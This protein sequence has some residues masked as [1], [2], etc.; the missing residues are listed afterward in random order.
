MKYV[1]AA[2]GKL[3]KEAEILK[4]LNHISLPKIIDIFDDESGLYIVQSFIEGVGLNHVLRTNGNLHEFMVLDFAKQLAKRTQRHRDGTE[5]KVLKI[6]TFSV[7]SVS[8]FFFFAK[9]T[10]GRPPSCGNTSV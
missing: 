4:S 9:T 10:C 8:Q 2:I 5:E 3:T 1:P 6:I 7:N